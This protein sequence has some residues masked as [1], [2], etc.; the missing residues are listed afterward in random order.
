VPAA[1]EENLTSGVNALVEP[2]CLPAIPTDTTPVPTF[3]PKH[4]KEHKHGHH[5]EGGGD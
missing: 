1:L 5:D 2:P 4:G 3:V